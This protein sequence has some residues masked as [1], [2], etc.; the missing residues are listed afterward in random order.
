MFRLAHLSDPHLGPLP[1]ARVA[2]LISKR[3]IG[4]VNWQRNRATSH[5]SDHLDAVVADLKVS[6]PDHVAVTGDLVNLALDAELEPA[7][8]WLSGLGD[9][10]DV[11]AIPGNHDAYVPGSV[12]KAVA[13]WRAFMSSDADGGDHSPFPFV[14]RRGPVGIVGLSSASASAPF[15]ATG[16]FDPAQARALRTALLRLGE[17]GLFRIVLIHHPPLR[18]VTHW[19]RRLIGA[20]RL[21]KVVHETGAELILHG[22]THTD[23]LV[24][25][26]GPGKQVP[27]VG[28]PS[29]SNAPGGKRPGGR[30]NLFEINGNAENWTCTMIER[31][32]TL[33]GKPVSEIRRRQFDYSAGAAVSGGV[34]EAVAS[35]VAAGV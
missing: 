10:N 27:V 34:S 31:G 11:S 20:A 21:R 30:Y 24:W 5:T 14:R 2:E 23:D 26:E 29:A 33:P 16:I 22:H 35:G 25:I 13:K 19:Y 8:L 1:D 32:L 6:E 17:E 28:V 4:Y 12:K 3:V 15:M 18:T 9:P 7:R